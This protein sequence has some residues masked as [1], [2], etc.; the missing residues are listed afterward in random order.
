[1]SRMDRTPGGFAVGQLSDLS[2]LET[3]VVLYLRLWSDG[4]DSQAAVWNDFAVGLGAGPGRAALQ[5]FEQ[6]CGLFAEHGRRPLMRHAVHCAC[7]GA[8]EACFANFVATATEGE[9]EDA[10]LLATL[11]VRPDIAPAVTGLATQVGLAL[12]RMFLRHPE[13]AP[14]RP[15]LH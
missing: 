11:L 6:L 13:P 4:P 12:K 8:D 14:E 7:L 5:S 3:T 1:M 2:R 15:T 9:R 10:L